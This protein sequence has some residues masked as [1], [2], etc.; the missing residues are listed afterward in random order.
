MRAYLLIKTEPGKAKS[1]LGAVR[2]IKGIVE[3]TAVTG[4]YDCIATAEAED[5]SHLGKL[6]VSK[7][8]VLT[9]VRD[10]ITCLHVEL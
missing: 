2:R 5:V 10:T 1:V 8:Q 4:P 7:V 3:A 6:V 9:G